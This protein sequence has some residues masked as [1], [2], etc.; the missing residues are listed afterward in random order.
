MKIFIS[1]GVNVINTNLHT[2]EFDPFGMRPFLYVIFSG[3]RLH[4]W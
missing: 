2:Y 1:T 3:I 4:L